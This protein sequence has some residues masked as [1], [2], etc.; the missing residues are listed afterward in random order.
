MNNSKI[1]VSNLQN[2]DPKKILN[3][4]NEGDPL[5]NDNDIGNIIN[6]KGDKSS[7]IWEIDEFLSEDQCDVIIDRCEKEEFESLDYRDVQRLIFFDNNLQ[8]V[9]LLEKKISCIEIMDNINDPKYRVDPYGFLSKNITWGKNTGSINP[10]L[11]LNKYMNSVDFS[12]HRDSSYVNSL[13]S[14]SNYS[15]IIYLN[16]NFE[17]GE[18]IFRSIDETCN[19]EHNGLT[20]R[21]ELGIIQKH[22]YHDIGIKPKKGKAIIFDQRLLHMGKNVMGTKY[23]LRSD[24][25]CCGQMNTTLGPSEI[26]METYKLAQKLF[27]QAQYLELCDDPQASDLYERCISLRQSPHKLSECPNSLMSLISDQMINNVIS[28]TICHINRSPWK[29]VFKIDGCDQYKFIFLKCCAIYTIL[30]LTE[31][32]TSLN[33]LQTFQEILGKIGLTSELFDGTNNLHKDHKSDLHRDVKTDCNGNKSVTN[34]GEFILNI[35]NIQQYNSQI[36]GPNLVQKKYEEVDVEYNDQFL[37]TAVKSEPF[38]LNVKIGVQNYKYM[39]TR[40]CGC[41]RCLTDDCDNVNLEF[42]HDADFSLNIDDFQ[43]SIIE[44]DETENG[45]SGTLNVSSPGAISFNH[46][47]CLS[48]GYFVLTDYVHKYQCIKFEMSFDIENDLIS[49]YHEPK[50]I[51]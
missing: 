20:I 40:S 41:Q 13:T 6:F 38:T 35:E 49:I 14:R 9:H 45:Y 39:E 42:Y 33:A 3:I 30:I 28:P 2:L 11:R 17:H 8:L 4:F 15:I 27:R 26:E 46:A 25:I 37:E 22:N 7:I 44:I 51:M 5:L 50:I 24:L 36:Y 16:D 48:E 43:I 10:C 18:T 21:E 23:V 34:D 47:S 31:K 19:Y 12:W 1:N 32:A 29:N